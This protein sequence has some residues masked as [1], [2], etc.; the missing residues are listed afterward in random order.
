MLGELQLVE[1]KI[2]GGNPAVPGND[3][4]STSVCWL[5]ARAA[6][7]PLDPSAIAHFFGL[8]YWLISKVKVSSPDRARNSIDLVT[9]AVDASHGLVEHAIFGEDLVNRRAPTPLVV[10]TEDLVKIA[11]QQ[12]R[13]AVGHGCCFSSLDRVPFALMYPT[14]QGN[15]E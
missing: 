15:G 4:I 13:Y 7:Y 14:P 12:G 5:L 11:G 10:L 2:N 6:L 3:E 1:K 8:G 9:A